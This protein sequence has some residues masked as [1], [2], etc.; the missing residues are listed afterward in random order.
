MVQVTSALGVPG[1]RWFLDT[2]AAQPIHAYAL[3]R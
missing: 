1:A 2:L 3:L